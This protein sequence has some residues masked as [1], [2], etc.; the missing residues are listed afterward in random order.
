MRTLLRM[1]FLCCQKIADFKCDFRHQF[2]HRRQL[3]FYWLASQYGRVSPKHNDGPIFIDEGA[4]IMEGSLL[5][6]P[7]YVGKNS[8]I[9]MGTKV[10]ATAHWAKC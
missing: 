1:I 8:V 4:T 6:G 5:R 10:Y 9:K 7:L 2:D 3:D